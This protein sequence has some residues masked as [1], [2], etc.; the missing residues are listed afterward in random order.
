MVTRVIIDPHRR[1]IDGSFWNQL[2]RPLGAT[3]VCLQLEELSAQSKVRVL[4][5]ERDLYVTGKTEQILWNSAGYAGRLHRAGVY[6][7]EIPHHSGS[8]KIKTILDAL[9]DRTLKSARALLNQFRVELVTLT[10]ENL[11]QIPSFVCKVNEGK[12]TEFGRLS[13]IVLVR[14]GNELG[15]AN[16]KWGDVKPDPQMLD[17]LNP[18]LQE[19][20]K[21]NSRAN[22]I[23]EKM[24][25]SDTFR[26][27]YLLLQGSTSFDREFTHEL[28]HRLDFKG[29]QLFQDQIT[30]S[31]FN[32]LLSGLLDVKCERK[33]IEKGHQEL[34]LGEIEPYS[35]KTPGFLFHLSDEHFEFVYGKRKSE[36]AASLL[37]KIISLAFIPSNIAIIR[38]L[39][40]MCGHL[41]EI[42]GLVLNDRTFSLEN[43]DPSAV[44]MAVK[45]NAEGNPSEEPEDLCLSVNNLLVQLSA[46]P[47]RLKFD[48]V[49]REFYIA[50]R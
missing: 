36:V 45:K 5:K 13:F 3:S 14:E 34:L 43:L 21:T 25:G 2:T 24:L 18:Y 8:A 16:I 48:S 47:A 33:C 44:K 40:S 23:L 41:R 12:I 42:E 20:S 37:A 28:Q 10:S 46:S 31:I 29:K 11:S 49:S 1:A 6:A 39:K 4:V 22:I 17:R 30:G 50:G 35:L 27:R 38:A 15:S 7:F 9:S 19:I 32:Y 26:E